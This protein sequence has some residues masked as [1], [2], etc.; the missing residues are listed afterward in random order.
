MEITNHLELTDLQGDVKKVF[1]THY[2]VENVLRM[3]GG[4]QK[5]VT[6]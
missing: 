2:V 5:V 3:H 6:K 4:A 1:G